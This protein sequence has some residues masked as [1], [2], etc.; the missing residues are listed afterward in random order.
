M[1]EQREGQLRCWGQCH[2]KQ[3][4]HISWS[5]FI[6]DCNLGSI[7]GEFCWAMVCIP[8][9]RPKKPDKLLKYSN[10]DSVNYLDIYCPQNRS[11]DHDIVAISGQWLDF[12]GYLKQ[13]AVGTASDWLIT[14]LGVVNCTISTT[15]YHMNLHV[16]LCLDLGNS[17]T[18]PKDGLFTGSPD[19][20]LE[21]LIYKQQSQIYVCEVTSKMNCEGVKIIK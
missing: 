17:H 7:S 3:C 16:S 20:V 10:E 2:Q 6:P 1:L 5:I 19:V 9:A 15:L 14:N 21:K 18:Q 8:M 13:W 11:T 4:K 12:T